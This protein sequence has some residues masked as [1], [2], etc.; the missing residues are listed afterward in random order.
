M[1]EP[2]RLLLLGCFFSSGA[3]GLVYQTAWTQQF[4]FVFGASELAVVAVLAAYMAG[5]TLGTAAAARL[6]T[7]V[8]RPVRAY[9]L[10]ELGVALSALAVPGAL[11]LAT[12]LQVQLLGNEPDLPAAGGTASLLFHLTCS[13]LILLV[14]TALMGATLPLLVRFA[15]RTDDE[16]GRRVGSLYTANTLGAA[17]GALVAAFVLL[18][19]VGLGRTVLAGTGLNA[20]AFLLALPLARFSIAAAAA[21]APAPALVSARSSAPTERRWIL[22]LVLVSSAVA[23]TYEVLWTRLLTFV[24]GAS[25]YAFAVMLATFL[26]GIAIGSALAARHA[27][28]G[29]DGRRGFVLAQ[30]GTAI[31]SLAAFHLVNRL[32]DLATHLTKAGAGPLVS[33][34]CLSALSLLPGAICMGATFPFAV[35]VLAASASQASAAA[36]RVYAWSTVGAVVGAVGG[37]LELLPRLRF[38]GT[39]LVTSALGAALAVAAALGAK[40]LLWR[41]AA[42]GLVIAVLLV[43]WPPQPPWR[44]LRH[45][46]MGEKFSNDVVFFAVG[47]S[48]TVLL[49]DMDLAWRL[50]TNGLPESAIQAPGTRSSRY[51]IAHWLSL[52]A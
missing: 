39:I 7:R 4:G 1:A 27:R 19:T 42:L 13:F 33:G 51:G 43:V 45:S 14:P 15:V 16:L 8:T 50:T 35:R 22:P 29:E 28:T 32:P 25:I 5:L 12:V 24:L 23:F 2:R 20:M 34:V 40:P 31:L 9:A 6:V 36:A 30:A 21:D 18:P 26:A 44:L 52:L 41:R 10:L 47:R 46:T 38:D 17:A 11:R 48:A 3:A 49:H 37:G